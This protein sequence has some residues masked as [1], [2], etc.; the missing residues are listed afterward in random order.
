MYK[1][2][3]SLSLLFSVNIGFAQSL[4]KFYS[5]TSSNIVDS[6]KLCLNLENANF[7]KN[8]EYFNPFYAGY[9]L[10]GYFIQATG[11]YSPIKKVNIKAGVHLQKYTGINKFSEVLPIFSFEYNFTPQSKLIIGTLDN[12][13]SKNLSE[14]TFDSEKY[15]TQNLQNGLEY[16]YESK[17]IYSNTWIDW[18][19]YIFHGSGY[20]EKF[21]FGSCHSYS[22]SPSNK[23]H[24]FKVT[25]EALISHIGGQIDISRVKV[26]SLVNL[27]L[28]IEYSYNFAEIGKLK[29]KSQYITFADIS[30]TKLR[31]YILGYGTYSLVS[32]EQGSQ[33]FALSHWFGNMFIS[34][35]GNPLFESSA[36]YTNYSEAK[37]AIV[38]SGYLL[39]KNITPYIKLGLGADV[40]FDLYN[41]NI[42]YSFGVYSYIY[43]N[44]FIL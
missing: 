22:F 6:S 17:S 19:Q 14:P 23:K 5:Q 10:P 42:D 39:K 18:Q 35:A 36:E 13:L 37:R 43:L 41:K 1:T 33:Y 4:S 20:P 25:A 8:N 26:E 34:P 15:L 28:G 11:T 7:F 31:E 16:V 24:S 29:F 38:S 21:L 30:P 2:L 3:L 44:H 27:P 40:Y 12:P 32:F 9:T